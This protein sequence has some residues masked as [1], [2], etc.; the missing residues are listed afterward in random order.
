MLE[1]LEGLVEAARLG[2]DADEA[3]L[4]E[5]VGGKAV[6]NG[7]AVDLRSQAAVVVSMDEEVVIRRQ[8]LKRMGRV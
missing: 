5:L 6:A 8:G 3:G 4:R 2:V 1:H 7:D